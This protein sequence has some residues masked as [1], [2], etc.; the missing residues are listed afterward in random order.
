MQ[1]FVSVASFGSKTVQESGA[2]VEVNKKGKTVVVKNAEFKEHKPPPNLHRDWMIR[3]TISINEAINAI[4]NLTGYPVAKVK[5]ARVV[6]I[7]EKF[8]ENILVYDIG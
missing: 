4:E 8:S 1:V 2:K 7:D 3:S 6:P 5:D